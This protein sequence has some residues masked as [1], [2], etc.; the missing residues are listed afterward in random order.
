M[1]LAVVLYII[2]RW[3]RGEPAVT[4]PAVLSGAFAI[5]VIA[6][7][8]SG[9][10]TQEVARGFAWLFLI[11]A[12]YAALPGFFRSLTL[13]QQSA[14]TAARSTVRGGLQGA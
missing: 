11:V 14:A 8:D 6:L 13:A 4:L 12:A 1:A 10:R 3:T 5:F 9:A 7:L 2:A